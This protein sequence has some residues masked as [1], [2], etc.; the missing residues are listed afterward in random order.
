MKKTLI[1][2]TLLVCSGLAQAEE[3]LRWDSAAIS[4]QSVDLDGETFSGFGLS[5][6]K[7]ISDDFFVTGSYSNS[8][9]DITIYES[10]K[11]DLDLDML[12]IGFG[13][14]YEL[15]QS[16]DFFGIVSYEDIELESSYLGNSLST[17][18]NGYGLEAGVRSMVTA[19]IELKGAIKYINI[20]DSSETALNV[21]AVYNFTEQFA[22]SIGYSN[23]DDLDV[24]SIAAVYYF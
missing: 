19:D 9:D 1:I 20:D 11:V 14:R 15:T 16:T 23:S 10:E 22:A 2:S 18:D 5:A 12:S 13:Y 6:S 3:S 24:L 8:S 4:Y 21:A 17:G 7:L